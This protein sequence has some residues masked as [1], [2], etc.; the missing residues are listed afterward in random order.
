M[1]KS[2]QHPRIWMVNRVQRSDAGNLYNAVRI[3][4]GVECGI[5]PTHSRELAEKLV[6]ELNARVTI[7]K[8][9]QS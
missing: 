9:T 6:S 8:A 4:D 3:S 7:A 2:K 5:T 1:G